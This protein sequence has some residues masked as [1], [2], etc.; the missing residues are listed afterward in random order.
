LNTGHPDDRTWQWSVTDAQAAQGALVIEA[1]MLNPA[2][3]LANA[4]AI[5]E[6][7]RAN[8]SEVLVYARPLGPS[9]TLASR[10]VQWTPGGGYVEMI[11]AERP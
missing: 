3:A 10:R 11:L 7:V 4:R 1:V 6:P 9:G 8:Y 2:D 5:V